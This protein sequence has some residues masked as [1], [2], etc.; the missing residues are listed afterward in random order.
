MKHVAM[1]ELLGIRK[2]TYALFSTVLQKM[3]NGEIEE[4]DF[5]MNDSDCCFW[6]HAKRLIA[7]KAKTQDAIISKL[8]RV[9]ADI[10]YY[11][12]PKDGAASPIPVTPML[13]TP[14]LVTF[15]DGER[16][17]LASGAVLR[18]LLRHPLMTLAVVGLIHYQAVK[19][20]IKRARFY[21]KPHPPHETL[22]R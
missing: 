22:T 5:K 4:D 6:G 17:D 10:H 8:N 2:E 13:V 15:V 1:H 7:E 11:D 21:R 20:W 18:A 16:R 19:L 14:M 9:R 3:Q 12:E